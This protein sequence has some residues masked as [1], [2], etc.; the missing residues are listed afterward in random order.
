MSQPAELLD[1]LP[2]DF[3]VARVEA[4]LR[5]ISARRALVVWVGLSIGGWCML[6]ALISLVTF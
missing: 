1:T 4:P 6:A 2:L 5:P 3:D